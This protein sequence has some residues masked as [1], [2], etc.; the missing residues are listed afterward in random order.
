M[1]KARD[2]GFGSREYGTTVSLK[3]TQTY[4]PNGE[5][6]EQTHDYYM[7]DHICERFGHTSNPLRALREGGPVNWRDPSAYSRFI[8]TAEHKKGNF[9]V[10]Q[11]PGG[12]VTEE[13]ICDRSMASWNWTESRYSIGPGGPNWPLDLESQAVAEGLAKV[14]SQ[15]ASLGEDLAQMRQ[16]YGMLTDAVHTLGNA[17][18]AVK[19]RDLSGLRRFIQ[20]PRAVIRKGADYWLQYEYG[21]KPLVGEVWGAANELWNPQLRTPIMSFTRRF[22]ACQTTLIPTPNREGFGVVDLRGHLKWYFKLSNQYMGTTMDKIGLSNPLS[23]GWNL[24]PYTFVVD[25][26]FPIGNILDSWTPPQGTDFIGGYSTVS[27]IGYG[28]T[29]VSVP[30]WV[31]LEPAITQFVTKAMERRVYTDWPTAGMYVKSPFTLRHGISS[32]ALFLQ[33]L[34]K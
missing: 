16:S 19:R 7:V 9:I 29:R 5:H 8:Y 27:W 34:L 13:H 31:T 24:I 10:N 1:V 6:Y 2:N 26:M 32:I 14:K 18:M 22:P 15:V 20:D 30:S 11:W 4:L 33:N 12:I 21:W 3:N 23:L 17:L 28:E 25:W